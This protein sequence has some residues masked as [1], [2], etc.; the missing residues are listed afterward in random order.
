[1][2]TATA[3]EGAGGPVDPNLAYV[4]ALYGDFSYIDFV[5]DANERRTILTAARLSN[6]AIPETVRGSRRTP[7]ERYIAD[8]VWEGGSLADVHMLGEMLSGERSA[9]AKARSRTA[10]TIGAVA[11]VGE[12]ALTVVSRLTSRVP[13]VGPAMG[14]VA[15]L[16]AFP[17]LMSKGVADQPMN[18]LTHTAHSLIRELY[19]SHYYTARDLA[20]YVWA[21]LMSPMVDAPDVL[22]TIADKFIASFERTLRY[23]AA[24]H[25]PRSLLAM[26]QALGTGASAVEAVWEFERVEQERREA[27][28]AQ[29][30]KFYA[31]KPTRQPQ[32]VELQQ[33]RLSAEDY[34]QDAD[35]PFGFILRSLD[36]AVAQMRTGEPWGMETVAKLVSIIMER[37]RLPEEPLRDRFTGLLWDCRKGL[38]AEL[39]NGV[40]GYEWQI[41][42]GIAPLG[43]LRLAD[44]FSRL[45]SPWRTAIGSED[46]RLL[47]SAITAAAGDWYDQNPGKYAHHATYR[48]ALVAG[49][50]HARTALAGNAGPALQRQRARDLLAA[51]PRDKHDRTYLLQMLP[52]VLV[53][54]IEQA[55]A[56]AKGRR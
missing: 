48:P 22:E 55:R 45:S 20:P 23:R 52:R 47:S 9:G 5:A 51:L 33:L 50:I 31:P 29:S 6:V 53:R 8:A 4:H 36:E 13:V 25:A 32:G 54:A 30:R 17:K 27:R 19:N 11:I 24:D 3:P 1:M 56:T 34:A 49:Y 46:A 42:Q 37:Q 18:H 39:A 15:K 14:L 28:A 44:E 43:I 21:S 35:L 2:E 40:F 38:A 26:Y 10:K 7:S 41:R 12:I 16:P